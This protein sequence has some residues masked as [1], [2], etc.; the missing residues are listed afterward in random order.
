[1]IISHYTQN[2]TN[3]AESGIITESAAFLVEIIYL[4]GLLSARSS[5]L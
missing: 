4:L 5:N 2:K 3:A 1:M